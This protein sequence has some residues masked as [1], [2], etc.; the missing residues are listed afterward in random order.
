MEIQDYQ[1]AIK[2]YV[3]RKDG[4]LSKLLEYAKLFHIE[5]LVRQYMEVL[6]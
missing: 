3:K 6:I 1:T 5:R 4:N 2:A